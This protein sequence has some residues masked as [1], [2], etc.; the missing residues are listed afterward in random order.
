MSSE[1]HPPGTSRRSNNWEISKI[2]Y[3]VSSN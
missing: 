2:I 1:T 3:I